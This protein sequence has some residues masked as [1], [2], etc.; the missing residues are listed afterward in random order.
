VGVGR[1]RNERTVWS[2]Y[3]VVNLAL[4]WLKMGL[5]EGNQVC[6]SSSLAILM[7]MTR[8]AKLVGAQR[9]G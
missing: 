2:E 4:G 6:G 1:P 7:G 3:A 8:I 5:V 9:G